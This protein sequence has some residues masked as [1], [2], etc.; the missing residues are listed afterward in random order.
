MQGWLAVNVGLAETTPNQSRSVS[1]GKL[2]QGAFPRESRWDL[3]RAR[4]QAI[5]EHRFDG[6]S[7]TQLR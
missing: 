3:T 1:I 4:S 2:Y 6:I 5:I 7:K